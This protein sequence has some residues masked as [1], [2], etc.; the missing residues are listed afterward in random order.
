MCG[1][2]GLVYRDANRSV[3]MDRLKPMADAIAHRGPDADGFFVGSDGAGLA[4]RRLAI[5]DLTS[6]GQPMGNED[7]S[8]Q[9]VFNGEIYN[10]PELREQ[11]IELGHRFR[12]HSDTETIVHLYEE[13]GPQLVH[14]LRGMFAFAIWDRP[15]QRLV[16]ARDH[17]GQKPLYYSFDGQRLLFGSEIK[18]ILAYGGV[19]RELDPRALEDYLAFG[20]VPGARSIFA[21]IKKLQPASILVLDRSDWSCNIQRYWRLGGP[22]NR[23]RSPEQWRQ[24]LGTKLVET[25]DAHR[26]ADVPIGAFLSGGLDSSLVTAVLS[27]LGDEA[28]RTFSIG[29][30]EK[31][32][33]ELEYARAV[34]DQFHTNHT[35]A[36]VT[37]DA[38]TS[39][40]ALIT[41]Y[42]EPFADASAIPTMRVAEL[43]SEQLKVVLSGDGG[44][45]GF[46][47]YSRYAHDLREA[48]LR[49]MIPRFLRKHVLG[50]LAKWWP[51]ADWLP[52]VLRAKTLLTNLSLEP[53][54]AYANTL[55]I[56]RVPLRKQ[57]LSA[58]L[59][60]SVARLCQ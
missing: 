48:G 20:F 45:E 58:S 25:V 5:I 46:G 30:Q 22:V 14:H 26:I 15:R 24:E 43:A 21:S 56:C 34:A 51:K 23:R 31:K 37:A 35:E 57:L 33:S 19:P 29:F 59:R 11:L 53:A 47:G 41:Y 36:I 32:F 38:I 49:C 54:S 42:D 55:C 17:F 60:D 16:L 28:V 2:A 8:I 3:S 12:T 1:I 39:L 44:D 27:E 7:D 18:A 6:G 4:H 10:F 9:I 52:R 40:Q 13:H 50:P